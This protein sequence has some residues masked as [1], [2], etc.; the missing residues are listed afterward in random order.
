MWVTAA[1]S[2]V[3]WNHLSHSLVAMKLGLKSWFDSNLFIPSF[4]S[5]FWARIFLQGSSKEH[6][7]LFCW[8]HTDNS[9]AINNL[10]LSQYRR[11]ELWLVPARK[12]PLFNCLFGGCLFPETGSCCV[13]HIIIEFRIFPTPSN[14]LGLEVHPPHFD[15]QPTPR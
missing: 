7:V 4:G 3:N 9:V 5:L 12:H 1:L 14:V 6:H 15:L 10:F 2:C 13:A 11:V 8:T